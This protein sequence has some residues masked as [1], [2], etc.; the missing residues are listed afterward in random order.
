MNRDLNELERRCGYTFR[1]K[2][3]FHRALTHSSYANE[4]K[5]D[6][7]VCNERLEF[8]GD[9]VL[10]VVSSD[11]LYHKYPE[12]PEGELSK[13]RAS[14][15][16]EPTLAYCAADLELGSYLLL[17]KGEE[18][19]GGRERNSVVSDAMEALIGSIYLDGG[20][21]NAKEFIH[22][23]I[24][25]DIEQR[26]IDR[27]RHHP[28]IYDRCKCGFRSLITLRQFSKFTFTSLK[29]DKQG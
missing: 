13:I 16:C 12:K 21:A 15:V 27:S 4:H 8:L 3:L 24:L 28:V 6:K 10:E 22:R 26:S 7:A 5:K 14:L 19:T 23:F 1:D 11:F 25:N 2:N 20:F 29:N 18:A 9:A 17:G